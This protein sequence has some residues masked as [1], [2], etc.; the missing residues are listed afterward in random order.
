MAGYALVRNRWSEVK[1]S[2]VARAALFSGVVIGALRTVSKT[3]SSGRAA[4]V[5][6]L[7][8]LAAFSGAMLVAAAT[9]SRRS[10]PIG[11]DDRST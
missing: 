4:Y 9:N 11:A 1:V 8:A 10:A 5:G 6:V 2:L 7:A 3:S